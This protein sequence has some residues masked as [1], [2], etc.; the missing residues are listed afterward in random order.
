MEAP[1]RLRSECGKQEI[2]GLV[3]AVG[4]AEEKGGNGPPTKR[5]R[6][7]LPSPS[8][9]WHSSNHICMWQVLRRLELALKG[10]ALACRDALCNSFTQTQAG[11]LVECGRSWR[12]N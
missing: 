10:S 5:K 12:K 11:S 1:Q 7:L 3:G 6:Q 8:K 4:D 9:R 2:P